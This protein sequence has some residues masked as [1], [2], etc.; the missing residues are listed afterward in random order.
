MNLEGDL[1]SVMAYLQRTAN[2]SLGRIYDGAEEK[3]QYNNMF[4]AFSFLSKEIS[5]P[6]FLLLLRINNE[7]KK[8]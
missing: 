1:D 6:G 2:L 5:E 4:A 3:G 7:L 8:A